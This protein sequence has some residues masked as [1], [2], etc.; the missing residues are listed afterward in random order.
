MNWFCKI[1]FHT[2]EQKMVFQGRLWD[3]EI[4]MRGYT[5]SNCGKR[6]IKKGSNWFNSTDECPYAEAEAVNWVTNK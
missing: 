1:G 6:Y 3:F 2:L 4:A 5:C